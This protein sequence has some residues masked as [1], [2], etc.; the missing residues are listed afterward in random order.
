M[1]DFMD[2]VPQL[3][4]MSEAVCTSP[5]PATYKESMSKQRH[6]VQYYEAFEIYMG[7]LVCNASISWGSGPL[8]VQNSSFISPCDGQQHNT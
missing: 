2:R 5:V 6:P 3:W 7:S 4:R 1:M 8:Q